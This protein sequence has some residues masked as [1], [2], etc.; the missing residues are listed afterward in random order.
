LILGAGETLTGVKWTQEFPQTNYEVTLE[1]QRLQGSDFFCGMTFPV[2]DSFCSLIVG[3]W[4]GSVIGLSNIDGNDASE[5]ETTLIRKLENNRWYKIRLQ[6]APVSV[7]IWMDG[8]KLIDLD[9][10]GKRLEVR[11]EVRL[12][13]PFGFAS[14]QTRAALRNIFL[15][16]PG[17]PAQAR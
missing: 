6:V 5:N 7:R 13:R 17:V 15:K 10:R 2:G 3:G 14:W 9:P 1:A 12:S 4:A 8:E 11:P 16:H